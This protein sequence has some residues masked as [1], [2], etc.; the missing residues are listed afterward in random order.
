M[1]D[2][3]SDLKTNYLAMKKE[4]LKQKKIIKEFNGYQ[5]Q[6]LAEAE[7]EEKLLEES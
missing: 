4:R 6:Q 7:L 2:A 5:E 3:T 1:T